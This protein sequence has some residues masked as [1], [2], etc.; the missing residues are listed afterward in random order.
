MIYGRG[1]NH[2]H[3]QEETTM[4]SVFQTTDEVV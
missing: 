4:N 3:D 1:T 2:C